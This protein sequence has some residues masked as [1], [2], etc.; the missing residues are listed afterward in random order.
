MPARRRP[1]TWW[2]RPNQVAGW[3]T[4]ILWMRQQAL[5]RAA[6]MAVLALINVSVV[7]LNWQVHEVSALLAALLAILFTVLTALFLKM[8][9]D[10]TPMLHDIDEFRR[11]FG[12]REYYDPDTIGRVSA[13]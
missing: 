3:R 6:W 10:M 4:N 11:Q 13:E 12:D 7:I 1:R 2:T 5:R 8:R 9:Y